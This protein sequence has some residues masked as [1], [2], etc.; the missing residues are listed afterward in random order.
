MLAKRG[1]GEGGGCA[2]LPSDDKQIG[3]GLLKI[4]WM[5][6]GVALKNP[7]PFGWLHRHYSD[8]QQ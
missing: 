8:G 2:I 5:H 7:F 1:C 3:Q 6:A 4:Q